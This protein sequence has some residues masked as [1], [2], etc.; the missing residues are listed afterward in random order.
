[1]ASLTYQSGNPTEPAPP[2]SALLR[3]LDTLAE[4]QMRQ[5]HRVISRGHKSAVE[6][7]DHV[8]ISHD[9]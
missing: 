9:A 4:W 8:E 7:E 6:T 5:S 3:I 2:R 1:M